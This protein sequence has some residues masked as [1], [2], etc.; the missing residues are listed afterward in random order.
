MVSWSNKDRNQSRAHRILQ[1]G[2]GA[3]SVLVLLMLGSTSGSA[4][5][6][7][8]PAK[9]SRAAKTKKRNSE[10]ERAILG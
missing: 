2:Q 3:K 9:K 5:L 8:R 10:L 4:R 7:G 1:C 6:E